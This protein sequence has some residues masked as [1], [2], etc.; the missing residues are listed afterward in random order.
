MSLHPNTLKT[1]IYTEDI[2]DLTFSFPEATLLL[3]SI[4]N[5]DLCPGPIFEHAQFSFG[6][7]SESGLSDLMESL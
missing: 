2:K 6:I 3:V 7:L 1:Q 5:R 4:K